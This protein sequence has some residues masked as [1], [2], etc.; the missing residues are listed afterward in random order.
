M[1]IQ[2]EPLVY[3]ASEGFSYNIMHTLKEWKYYIT[4]CTQII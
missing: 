3:K 4:N 2:L 1:Q